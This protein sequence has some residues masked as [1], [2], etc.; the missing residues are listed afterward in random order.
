MA[1]SYY[2]FSEGEV[3]AMST[4]TTNE[5][6]EEMCP[7]EAHEYTEAELMDALRER[8]KLDQYAIDQTAALIN[9]LLKQD[10]KGIKF[11]TTARCVRV[12][13][14]D[15]DEEFKNDLANGKAIIIDNPEAFRKKNEKNEHGLQS[16]FF[17]ADYNNNE[18]YNARFSCA[19]GKMIGSMYADGYT[20]CPECGT[21]I[22]KNETDLKK[23]GWVYLHG[24]KVLTPIYYEKLKKLLGSIDG[25]YYLDMILKVHYKKSGQ[26]HTPEELEMINKYGFQFIGKG[27]TWLREHMSDVLEWCK[28]K[29]GKKNAK[30]SDLYDEIYQDQYKMFCGALPIYSAAMRSEMPGEKDIKNYRMKINTCFQAIIRC[31]NDINSTANSPRPPCLNKNTGLI[32]TDNEKID[33]LLNKIQENAALVFNEEYQIIEGKKGIIQ[34]KLIGGRHDFSGRSII[35]PGARPLRA[36]EVEIPYV[37]FL[38]LFRFEI[39]N[40]WLKLY[41]T[42]VEEANYIL[43]KALNTFD[44]KVYKIMTILLEEHKND[45]SLSVII[46]RNPC[47]NMG[48]HGAFNIVYIKPNIDDKTVTLN[49]R[50]LTNMNADFDGDQINIYRPFGAYIEYIFRQLSSIYLYIDTRTGKVNK[51]MLPR[52]DEIAIINELF[53]LPDK[54]P[55]RE[56]GQPDRSVKVAHSGIIE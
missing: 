12:Y 33:I 46:S 25:K 29:K 43:S 35:V 1:T 8:R 17:G 2:K 50:V 22:T 4:E 18:E 21:L 38:S 51:G 13:T 36:E 52:K 28:K 54:Q 30:V 34:S 7:D 37:T 56:D 53:S 9:E 10:P 42:S 49:T 19:C 47:I 6:L 31:A 14:Y 44:E 3:R 16:P 5:V 15:F 20:V 40:M 55:I 45:H 41:E 48:S 23:F 11:N 26:E 32:Q 24:Y 27:M 39:L